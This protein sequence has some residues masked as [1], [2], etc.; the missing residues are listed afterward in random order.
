MRLVSSSPRTTRLFAEALAK[1]LL[2]RPLRFPHATV[3][4]L[5]G[6]LGVGKTLFTQAFARAMGVRRNLPS[7]TFVFVRR[8]PLKNNYYQNL[9]HADA[10]RLRNAKKKTLAP[11]GFFEDLRN[12]QNLFLVEWADRIRAAIPHPAIWIFLRHPSR[13]VARRS[14][15]RMFRFAAR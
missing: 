13:N 6:S 12:P 11:L 2:R 4:A 9:F 10:Y 1:E 7:P 8:Y 14:S 5:E 3:I 15:I